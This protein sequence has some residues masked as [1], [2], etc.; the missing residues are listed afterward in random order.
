MQKS[1]DQ[2]NVNILQITSIMGPAYIIHEKG[3]WS[4]TP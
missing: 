1:V 3:G 4:T 2:A